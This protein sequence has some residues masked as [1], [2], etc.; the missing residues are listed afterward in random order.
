MGR[1]E[2]L[3]T[4]EPGRI[5]DLVLLAA[6]PTEDVSAVRTRTAVIRAGWLH[7]VA[8]LRYR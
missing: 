4:V 1:G 6:D 2:E 8:S 3:G 7:T 5:A